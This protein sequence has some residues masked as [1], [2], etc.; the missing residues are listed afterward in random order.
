MILSLEASYSL[1]PAGTPEDKPHDMSAR[2]LF[3]MPGRMP[4]GS[5]ITGRTIPTVSGV[6]MHG[7]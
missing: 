1:P 6:V 3:G 7:E 2:E 5:R 4:S